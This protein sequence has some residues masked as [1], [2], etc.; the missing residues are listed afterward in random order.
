MSSTCKLLRSS[1]LTGF[2]D[3]YQTGSMGGTGM[4]PRRRM[5]VTSE[6][7]DGKTLEQLKLWNSQKRCYQTTTLDSRPRLASVASVLYMRRKERRSARG[8]TL[9]RCTQENLHERPTRDGCHERPTCPSCN[10]A[11]TRKPSG[12]WLPMARTAL[13][14]F[15]SEDC[16]DVT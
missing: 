3:V 4:A 11:S 6:I 16:S 15:T 1:I 2:C 14:A 5:L 12:H 13:L 9:N 10:L 7:E 8:P